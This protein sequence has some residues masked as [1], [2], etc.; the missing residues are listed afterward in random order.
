[1][2]TSLCQGTF[3]PSGLFYANVVCHASRD[4][5]VIL[6]L[7][8]DTYPEGA[9]TEVPASLVSRFELKTKVSALCWVQAASKTTKNTK[10]KQNGASTKTTAAAEYYLAVAH[11]NGISIYS[12][13]STEPISTLETDVIGMCGSQNSADLWVLGSQG[14]VKKFDVTTEVVKTEFTY[15][16]DTDVKLICTISLDGEEHLVLC[17]DKLSVISPDAPSKPV[18]TTRKNKAHT[19]IT[20]V[21]QAGSA[22]YITREDT[23][24]IQ[25]IDIEGKRKAVFE[26]SSV[27]SSVAVFDIEGSEIMAAISA[28]TFEFFTDVSVAKITTNYP[29]LAGLHNYQ[30]KFISA[31]NSG[32]AATFVVTPWA[33]GETVLQ[34][35]V[36]AGCSKKAK[37]EATTVIVGA[38]AV[39]KEGLTEGEAYALLIASLDSST[40]GRVVASQQVEDAVREIVQKLTSAQA[41]QLF[42]ALSTMVSASPSRSTQANVWLKWTLLAHGGYLAK[43]PAQIQQLIALKQ[44]LVAGTKGL[45][46]MLGLQGRLEF[47]KS[48]LALRNEIANGH[49]SEEE[50]EDEVEVIT[51]DNLV[52]ANGEID[53]V[54]SE[55]SGADEDD[56]DEE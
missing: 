37:T 15:K 30:N 52:Y 38:E 31:C 25:M 11:V 14:S 24:E 2:T 27:P 8:P 18:F 12:P 33:H 41:V 40:V 10:R 53:D 3:A 36:P 32:A 13:F 21:A 22:L 35:K 4:A 46:A 7:S 9:I 47:L 49:E 39:D 56:E 45:T 16:K 42:E 43:Q 5:V 48:Q 55:E 1:M 29:C 50:A 19:Q 17:S 54:V 51:S 6:P 26:V 20:A 23:T 44:A 34:C 28:E